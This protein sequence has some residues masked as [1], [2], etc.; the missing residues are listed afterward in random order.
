MIARPSVINDRN[1]SVGN[2]GASVDYWRDIPVYCAHFFQSMPF[3][4]NYTG[5]LMLE[6]FV[7]DKT[8]YLEM[9]F[10]L[11]CVKMTSQIRRDVNFMSVHE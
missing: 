3:C 1:E 10:I 4:S 11:A 7:L 8:P 5:G 9:T 2:I 6:M